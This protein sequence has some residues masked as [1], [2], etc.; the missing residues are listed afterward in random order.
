[1][2]IAEALEAADRATAEVMKV[3]GAHEVALNEER[4]NGL[5]AFLATLPG[6]YP[7]NL[8]KL[9]VTNKNQADMSFW[10]LPSE[11]ERR[12]PFTGGEHLMAFET[13]DG[14]LFYFNLHVQDNA[15]TLVL[16][17]AG[18]GKSFLLNALATYAQKE[19][20]YTFIFDIGGS[21]R[22]LTELFGGSYIQIRPDRMPFSINPFVLDP[23][24][25]N[26]DF[27]FA[28]TKL[29]AESG[30]HRM[31]DAEERD[32]FEALRSI[33]VLDRDQR[34]LLTLSTTV[35]KSIGDCLKRWTE[36]EQ[37]GAYFDNVKDTV[38][39][40]HFQCVDFEGMERA[41]VVLEA[42]LFYLLHRA[43][44]IIYDESLATTFKLFIV[45]EAWRF[46]KHQTT[47]A[48]II[49]ALKTWRKKNAAMIL[50]TQSIQDL[51]GDV[52]RPVADACPTK[53]LLANPGLD[54]AVYG[55]VL[56][57]TATEQDRVRHLTPKRQFLLKR[58][59]L[60]KVLNLNV[61]PESYWLFT[62]NPYEAKR[63]QEAIE[64][65]GLKKALETLKGESV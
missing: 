64:R 12:N 36:G 41:G 21:Y 43:N 32:L 51:D 31:S 14:S 26:L 4:Y 1:M 53:L 5:N 56:G 42:I 16:G 30:G 47:R 9:L 57:L 28:F 13:E 35:R 23:T 39:F 33:Y 62:T 46:F 2:L 27:L 60:S 29:L 55:D 54:A 38:T 17:R 65:F 63:R 34:R 44:D 45:D 10:F 18:S 58:D 11:G 61:D 37:F 6:G 59:H 3:F 7:F 40:S 48:Y 24:P 50:A 19:R 15:H 49:E 22:W 20:P 25:R 52:L 8:R